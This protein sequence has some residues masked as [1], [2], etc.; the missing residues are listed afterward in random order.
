MFGAVV[1]GLRR[2]HDRVASACCCGSEAGQSSPT[3]V[4]LQFPELAYAVAQVDY[5]KDAVKVGGELP[6]SLMGAHA[7][8]V[9]WGDD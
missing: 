9:C 5:M 2:W 4:L 7:M 1:P 3:W 6:N 8:M